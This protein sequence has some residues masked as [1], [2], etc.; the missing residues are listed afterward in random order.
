M[1][2]TAFQQVQE[3]T[4]RNGYEVVDE[5]LSGAEWV[6]PQDSRLPEYDETHTRLQNAGVN[7]DPVASFTMGEQQFAIVDVSRAEVSYR[8]G[9][10]K[11]LVGEHGRT[12]DTEYQLDR[13]MPMVLVHFT[14]GEGGRTAAEVRPIRRGEHILL[15]RD[16]RYAAQDPETF[17]TFDYGD[18]P[19]ISRKHGVVSLDPEKRS[20]VVSDVGSTFGTQIRYSRLPEAGAEVREPYMDDATRDSAVGG[21]KNVIQRRVLHASQARSLTGLLGQDILA[22]SRKDVAEITQEDAGFLGAASTMGTRVVV[23]LL[24]DHYQLP[25]SRHARENLKTAVNK[26]VALVEA[27]DGRGSRQ[28]SAFKPVLEDINDD[29]HVSGYELLVA[30]G[31]LA[32]TPVNLQRRPSLRAAVEDYTS[33]MLDLIGDIA[34]ANRGIRVTQHMHENLNYILQKRDQLKTARQRAPLN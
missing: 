10:Y 31:A 7:G 23:E 28:A 34:E 30:L 25:R 27:L 14:R 19:S 11:P 4:L 17:S 32:E 9:G 5:S 26:A 15:S 16:K 29:A 6:V 3:E 8:T 22:L 33:S 18:D 2:E 24:S 1:T 12:L 21:L 13:D 20:V